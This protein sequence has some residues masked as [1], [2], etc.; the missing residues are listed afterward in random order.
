MDKKASLIFKP[1]F[2]QAKLTGESHTLLTK[3]GA[4]LGPRIAFYIA[5]NSSTLHSSPGRRRPLLPPPLPAGARAKEKALL[6]PTFF[7]ISA[8]GSQRP[9]QSWWRK[10]QKTTLGLREL[11]GGG[12][13]DPPSDRRNVASSLFTTVCSRGGEGKPVEGTVVR[14]EGAKRTSE[15]LHAGRGGRERP[16]KIAPAL[17]RRS[18]LGMKKS[19]TKKCHGSHSRGKGGRVGAREREGK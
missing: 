5:K 16:L 19:P 13:G 3:N 12:V 17:S 9:L 10:R 1:K 7:A 15:N 4:P 8:R 14:R 11:K 18:C 6:P 2:L